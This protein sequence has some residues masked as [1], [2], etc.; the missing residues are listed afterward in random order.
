MKAAFVQYKPVYL[1]VDQNLDRVEQLI[2]GIDADLVVL[3]EVFATGYYFKDAEDLKKV[4]EP[5]DDGKTAKRFVQ[6]AEKTGATFVAGFP[7]IDGD[8]IFNSAMIVS[9]QGIVGSYRKVHLFFEEKLWYSP[10]NLGFPVFH[11]TDRNGESYQLGVMICFDWYY[12]ESARSLALAGADLIAHPSNLVRK[13]CPRAMPIR[14]LENHVYTIT[15]NRTGREVKNGSTLEFIGQSLIC[16]PDG[17][18]LVQAGRDEETVGIAEFDVTMARNRQI[19]DHN[20]LLAD[21]RPDAY[22]L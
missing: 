10:G 5:L 20:D 6:W 15:A 4:A 12:P 7:E 14:A 2:E 3:P 22:A 1:Q 19:T 16:N 17:D 11:V 18:V 9:K 13:D 8:E 21:R